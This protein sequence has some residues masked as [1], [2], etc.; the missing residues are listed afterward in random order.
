MSESP[1]E[2][3]ADQGRQPAMER[4]GLWALLFSGLGL[5]LPLYGILLSLV[6]ILQG[7]RAR[8]NAAAK[9]TAAPGAV[10]AMLLGWL[11]MLLWGTVIAAGAVVHEELRTWMD[12]QNQ[13]NTVTV[14]QEC[15]AELRGELEGRGVPTIVVDTF[16]D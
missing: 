10:P 15:D 12:C 4:G 16:L 6:G 7:R 3:H 2:P 5:I 9:E 13:A 11:G 14:T 8:R 1:T